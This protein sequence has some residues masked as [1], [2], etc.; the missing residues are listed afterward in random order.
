MKDN[1]TIEKK[2]KLLAVFSILSSIIGFSFIIP[3]LFFN[4]ANGYV[5]FTFPFGIVAWILAHKAKNTP[6]IKER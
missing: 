6:L 3:N 2:T 5:I 4:I 1:I